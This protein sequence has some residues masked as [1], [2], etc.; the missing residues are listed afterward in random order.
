M[1][2]DYEDFVIKEDEEDIILKNIRAI[3]S[4]KW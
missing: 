4:L 2:K 1:W 3:M